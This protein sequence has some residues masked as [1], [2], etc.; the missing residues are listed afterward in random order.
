M[1]SYSELLNT[2]VKAKTV[3][4]WNKLREDAKKKFDPS[5]IKRLDQSGDINTVLK[6]RQRTQ[7]Y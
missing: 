1:P 4:D 6:H 5:L 3:S 2:M 7:A